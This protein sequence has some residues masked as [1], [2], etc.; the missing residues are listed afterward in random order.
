MRSGRSLSTLRGNLPHV[1]NP[2]LASWAE[3]WGAPARE[4][5]GFERLGTYRPYAAGGDDPPELDLC[6]D[7]YLALDGVIADTV[8][9]IGDTCPDTDDDMTLF[10]A[11]RSWKAMLDN[12][13]ANAREADQGARLVETDEFLD[14]LGGDVLRTLTDLTRYI[15]SAPP[16]YARRL[17]AGR[18][19]PLWIARGGECVLSRT[20]RHLMHG[21]IT[22]TT[23]SAEQR[24]KAASLS[25]TR[26]ALDLD[27]LAW[28]LV[29]LCLSRVAEN[30]LSLCGCA[31]VG[32]W[33]FPAATIVSFLSPCWA[34][35]CLWCHGWGNCR[36]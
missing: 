30:C 16:Q 4:E 13:N 17:N 3:D 33:A 10:H 6:N 9:L 21:S 31:L 11:L 12:H 25:Q 29:M 26:A 24:G 27:P 15:G 14:T 8:K 23:S 34:D 5:R 28:F 35:L 2:G 20:L 18:R 1:N 32:H 22:S 19:F 7:R 36:R